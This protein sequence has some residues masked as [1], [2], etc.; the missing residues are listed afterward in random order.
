MSH[1]IVG[2]IPGRLEEI[3][4]RRSGRGVPARDRGYYKHKFTTPAKIYVCADGSLYIRPVRRGRK[5][6]VDLPS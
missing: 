4:Y 6:W 1:R 5:L 2:Q 3:R